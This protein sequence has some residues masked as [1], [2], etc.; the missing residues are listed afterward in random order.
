MTRIALVSRPGQ[1]LEIVRAAFRNPVK[2][3]VREFLSMEAVV[4]GLVSFPMHLLIMRV[5]SF[6][7]RHLQMLTKARRRFPSTAMITLAKE[8]PPALR[9]KI[10]ALDRSISSFRVLEE[11]LEV[12]DLTALVEKLRRGEPSWHRLHPRARRGEPV[13]VVDKRGLIHRGHFLDFAQMGA[14]LVVPSLQKFEVKDSVQL[15]YNSA[16]EPGRQ[17]RI[18]AKVVWSSFDGGIVDQFMGVKQQT[19]GL[20]FIA[21]Y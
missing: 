19:T 1:D 18:E 14:R 4:Q 6:E 11:P 12:G 8:I 10:A 16:S 5:Q 9:P 13:Q 17:H 20:R 21:T 15:I 2:F 7:E 3:T